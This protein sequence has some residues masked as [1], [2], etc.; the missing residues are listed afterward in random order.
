MKRFSFLMFILCCFA[1]TKL[2][3]QAYTDPAFPTADDVVTVYF[4]A[5]QGTGGL[6]DC[7]CDVYV[8]TGLSTN[9]NGNVSNWKYVK[10]QWGQVNADW[11]MTA[12]GN[13]LYSWKV[14]IKQ[15]FQPDPTDDIVKISFVF[16]NDKGTAEGKASGG[17]DIYLDM[18]NANSPFEAKLLS[19][20]NNAQLLKGK[21]E[22][23]AIKGAASK[24]SDLTITD[25]G[26]VVKQLTAAKGIDH[27]ITV[28]DENDHVVVFS[29]K[30][31]TEVATQTFKY[32]G[33]KAV[34]TQDPPL[35]AKLGA[36]YNQNGSITFMLYAP[37]KKNVY[38]VG[39]FNNFDLNPAYLMKRS[40]DGTRWWIT[41]DAWTNGTHTYQYAVDGSTR[42]A[43]PHSELIL[44]PANDKNIPAKSYPNPI[45]YP[46][47][48]EG[49][50]SVLNYP[51]K[52]YN[53]SAFNRPAKSDLVIYELLVRDFTTD[54]NFQSVIDT[55]SYLKHLGV[56]AVQFMPI[57]EFDNNF[58]WGYNP[59]F[60][61]ALDKFYGTPE[62]F[63]ELVDKCHKLGMAVILDVVFNHVSE[64]SPLVQMYPASTDT[65]VNAIPKHDFNVFSDFNHESPATRAYVDRCLEYW[66]EEYN[67][68]GYRFDL[69][70]GFTQKN[71]LG[72]SGAMAQY[73][74]SR[75][76]ILS[77]YNQTIKAVSGSAY[78]ILEHFA[79]NLE[80][81]EL[82]KLGMMLWANHQ[83]DY[84][85]PT[86][87]YAKG[88][89]TNSFYIKRGFTEPNLVAYMESHDEER[90]GY[91]ALNFGNSSGSY[92]VR[93]TATAMRRLEMANVFFYCIPGPKML[94]QFGELGYDYSINYCT[95]GSINNNCRLDPKPARWDYQDV[96]ERKRLHDVVASLA[97]I[98]QKYSVFQTT[99][100]V[101]FAGSLTKQLYLTGMDMDLIAL[102]NFD[103]TEQTI[104]PQ[105]NQ[106][107][108]WYNYF[109]G[110]SLNIVNSDDPINLKPGEYRLY[111]TKRLPKPIGGYKPYSLTDDK[112]IDVSVDFSVFPNPT[113]NEST[114]ISYAIANPSQVK[115]E[116]FDIYGRLVDT[117]I[118]DFQSSGNYGVIIPKLNAGTYFA[119]LT[120]NQSSTTKKFVRLK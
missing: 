92:S 25:N 8:H 15:F 84:A 80:E 17:K 112:N 117:T 93:D 120:I 32:T 104:T 5:S 65:Y 31:G 50:V 113:T 43:D 7:N 34:V 38:L 26:T 4:D 99:N 46:A 1:M 94:W 56:N 10:T 29:A 87:G 114:E 86:M 119:K 100:A 97:N 2:A 76:A 6:K 81:R 108:K 77:H 115:L 13:N 88:S 82:S 59:T 28:A 66:L 109:T 62:K 95:S 118:N 37:G 49:Y 42:V 107:G 98:K 44:D 18:Y 70:K 30:N 12:L 61:G 64:K 9:V 79:D 74:P 96:P 78:H 40:V 45:A 106:L 48:G 91:Q 89:I 63:K 27:T 51:K 35:T 58:S 71:T 14:N 22:T 36:T 102:G 47:K 21:N 52:K 75:I 53:W 83:Y 24:S 60:H 105:F 68:D 54:R 85:Q 11:K 23:I 20:S 90:A 69:S 57:N 110:D 73:D 16:R 72:N 101:I 39:D 41:I 111:T 33:V 116:I 103:V 19:P 3:A 55:L 67:I